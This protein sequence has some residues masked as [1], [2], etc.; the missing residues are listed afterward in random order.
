MKRSTASSRSSFECSTEPVASY[1]A[2]LFDFD[3]VLADSE[4]L[5]YRCWREILAPYG[6]NL[7]WEVYAANYIGTSD[8]LMLAQFCQ[9]ASPPVEL[10]T[11]IDQYPRKRDLFREMILR[12]LP[13]FEGCREFLETLGAYRLAVVSS[14]G[15][16]EIE[17]PL[18]R[19]GLRGYFQTLVCGGDVRPHKPAP[20]PYLLAAER[21]E[22]RRPLVIEDSDAGVESA[23]AA[24]F[25]V[26]RV[27]SPSEV[28]EAVQARL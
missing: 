20:D 17:P 13:F 25:D 12:E 23:R 21:L 8:R 4:P 15:R 2:I 6:I 28:R 7:E 27:N 26:I 11:L 22:A 9:A 16:L 18:E 1:D 5:H 10:Q 14:S 24:G 19:A 3:G